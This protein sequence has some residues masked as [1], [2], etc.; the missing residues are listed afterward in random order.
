[1]AVLQISRSS[2]VYKCPYMYVYTDYRNDYTFLY[3]C[4]Y[5]YIAIQEIIALCKEIGFFFANIL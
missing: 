4:V 1:M 3:K 2:K 5:R